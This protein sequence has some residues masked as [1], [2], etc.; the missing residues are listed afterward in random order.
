MNSRGPTQKK[1]GGFLNR[2]IIVMMILSLFLVLSQKVSAQD[3]DPVSSNYQLI[4]AGSYVIAMDNNLQKDAGNNNY[5]NIK[6]YGLL[7]T[8]LDNHIALYWAIRAGKAKDDTDFS[9]MAIQ[10]FPTTT[11]ASLLQFRAGPFIAQPTDTVGLDSLVTAFNAANPTHKVNVYQLTQATWVDIRYNLTGRPRAAILNDGGNANIHLRYMKVASMPSANYEQLST[12]AH[13]TDPDTCFTFASEPHNDS[14]NIAVIDSIHSFVRLGGN[15]LAQCAAIPTYEN[16][17]AGGFMTT[18]GIL[19]FA[20]LGV[21][22]SLGGTTVYKH[23]DLAF[24]Q[25]QGI[26]D[27]S[28]MAGSCGYFCLKPGSTFINN[29][30]MH[31]QHNTVGARDTIYQAASKIDTGAGHMVF[32]TG[33]HNYSDTVIGTNPPE[34]YDQNHI[35]GLR[36]YFN[37]MFIPSA[38]HPQCAFLTF[39][40][41]LTIAKSAT[42]L[43]LILGQNDTFTIIVTNLGPS[44][45]VPRNIRAVDTLPVGFTYLSSRTSGGTYNSITH[46]WSIDSL[47]Y[48][49]SDTL[50]IIATADS[51][52]P[53]TNTAFIIQQPFDFNLSNDTAHATVTVHTCMIINAGKD[54]AICKGNSIVL[55]GSPLITGGSSPFTY[56]WN[57]TGTLSAS[58]IP[59]PTATPVTTTTYKVTVTDF[60]SCKDSGMVT[61]TVNPLPVPSITLASAQICDGNSDTLIAGGGGTYVWSTAATTDTI[62]VSPGITTPYSLTVTDTNHCAASLTKDVI[63]NP[64]PIPSIILSSSQTCIGYKDT[65]IAVG[66]V[67]YRWSSTA[68][69]DTIIVSPVSNTTYSVTVTDANHCSASISNT[70]TVNPS[71]TVTITLSS[72]QICVGHSDTLTASGGGTYAWSNASTTNPLI[73]SPTTTTSYS[74]TVTS[75]NTCSASDTVTVIV[76]PLPTPVISLTSIQ[77]CSGHPD[78]LIAGGGINYNWSNAANTDTVIVSPTTTTQY[79]LT[80]TDANSCSDTISETVIVNPVP[81]AAITATSPQ[82]C[83][84]NSDTLTASGGGTYT[85]SNTANTASIVVSPP[86][87]STYTVTVTGANACYTTAVATVIVNPQPTLSLGPDTIVCMDLGYNIPGLSSGSSIIWVPDS[88]LS[89]PTSVSPRFFTKDSV[90]YTYMVIAIDTTSGC[91]DTGHLTIGTHTCV[92]YIIGAQAFTPNGDGTN[93]HYTLFSS[94]IASYE[95]R[96]YNRWGELVYQSSDLTAL[97]DTSKGW[98]GTYLG[99]PQPTDVFVFYIIAKDNFNKDLSQKGNITLLR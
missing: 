81:V 79:I 55:G 58:N 2:G 31:D 23:P 13:L 49:A 48:T 53:I 25:Y 64:L 3:L 83:I 82:I 95:I 45:T 68:N 15:F 87:D 63:V 8:L 19:N 61:I 21:G 11:A 65:L 41:D 30:D 74:V 26:F 56:S 50:V 43:N 44:T 14:N 24:T 37:A 86:A 84:G 46:V 18:T 77:T 29:G 67:N 47:Q 20:G 17:S 42:P 16:S 70:V 34:P 1:S 7:A 97:N 36:A 27:P 22:R 69:T 60:F 92:S 54:T 33:S 39:N 94:Q 91:A 71:P 80:V 12:G 51:S 6:A 96:I 75:V 72:A 99:K 66:G 35:N 78:T 9:A 76:N 93:D 57:P 52:G 90:N 59:N 89:D 62:I 85:W 38:Y 98:D 10:V 4:P 88:G 73:V 32:Y 28:Q 5:F 40:N